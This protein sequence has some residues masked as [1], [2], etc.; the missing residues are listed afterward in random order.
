[1]TDPRTVRQTMTHLGITPGDP[2]RR[3]GVDAPYLGRQLRGLRPLRA[4]VRTAPVGALDARA[5]AALPHVARLLRREGEDDAAQA[6][7]LLWGRLGQPRAEPP[8]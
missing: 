2:S 5:V 7:E 3:S 8:G 4:T 6:C 1:M